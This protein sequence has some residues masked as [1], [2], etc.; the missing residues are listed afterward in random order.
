MVGRVPLRA[1]REAE[2]YEAYIEITTVESVAL[3]R[4]RAGES[5][6]CLDVLGIDSLAGTRL[7]R[8]YAPEDYRAMLRTV[9]P[10][11]EDSAA[12]AAWVRCRRQHDDAS[13]R[14]AAAAIT[15]E[16]IPMP[17]SPNARLMFLREI[18]AAGGAGA[19]ERLVA[20]GGTVRERLSRAS[21][22]PIERTIDRWNARIDASRPERMRVPVTLAVAS[23]GW[24]GA[25]LALTLLRRGSWS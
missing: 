14:V 13:C 22:E 15:N 17:L 4:C 10:S 20:G 7:V 21:A 5:Q 23:L 19:Y 24:T 8:W 3:R 25:L 9:A 18:L 6:F 11:R 16:R 1:P 12:V 2:V